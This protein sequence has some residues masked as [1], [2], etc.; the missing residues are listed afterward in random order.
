MNEIQR[1]KII[2]LILKDADKMENDAAM[3][4]AHHDGGASKLKDNVKFWKLGM[5]K[6][7]PNEW[8]SYTRQ[9]NREN[10]PDYQ[11]YLLLKHKFED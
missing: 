4:G 10:D 8:D 6:K 11:K 1:E 3:G 5:M 7:F 2:E 9:Y